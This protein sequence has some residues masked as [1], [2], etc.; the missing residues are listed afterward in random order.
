M[1][2]ATKMRRYGALSLQS[3]RTSQ[4]QSGFSVSRTIVYAGRLVTGVAVQPRG[5]RSFR[6][7]SRPYAVPSACISIHAS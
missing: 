5:K 1:T 6:G 7:F 3:S 4:A 2:S